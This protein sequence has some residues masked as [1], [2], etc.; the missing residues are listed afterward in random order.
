MNKL[1]VISII[2]ILLYTMCVGSNHQTIAINSNDNK[3]CSN[4]DAVFGDYPLYNLCDPVVEDDSFSDTYIEG[5]YDCPTDI[6][7]ETDLPSNVISNINALKSTYEDV[8]TSSNTDWRILAAIDYRES[9]NNPS[10]SALNGQPF[11]V[12]NVDH[13]NLIPEN[14]KESIE[15]AIKIFIN[16]ASIYNIKINNQ[17]SD[18]DLKNAFL[19][20]N[21]G[22]LYKKSNT[23]A[24]KSPYVMNYFSSEFNDMR[25]PSIAEGE[26]AVTA[27]RKDTGNYGA[28]TIYSKLGGSVSCNGVGGVSDVEIV[29]IAQKEIGTAESP[30]GS[31]SGPYI[32]KYTDGNKEPWCADFVSWVYREAGRPF[33]PTRIASV[34][35]VVA[36]MQ[37][38]G[39][40]FKNGKGDPTP[41]DIVNFIG[42]GGTHI[43]I[44]EKVDGND[45]TT[46]EGN[47]S[48]KV[49]RR[50]Y[51]NYKLKSNIVGFG[52]LK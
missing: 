22:G 18:Q 45:L 9:K 44:V 27:G 1:R 41:G 26:V 49:S 48:N 25:W 7:S 47:S 43:G 3:E 5:S 20:Y 31:N 21:R 40:Y 6:G 38:N 15:M 37:E 17:I 36:Y 12:R 50:V 24:D 52:R 19:A 42:S 35:S 23:S 29:A 11:G 34:I 14:K 13:G 4:K 10:A 2:I 39:V 33:K 46:I 8:A 16:N 30:L 51:T 32:S 28:F